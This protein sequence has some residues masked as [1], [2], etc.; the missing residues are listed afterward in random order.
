[1][2]GWCRA[3]P[4]GKL[5]RKGRS[6]RKGMAT[7]S[8][9]IAESITVNSESMENSRK[10]ISTP[11]N[12]P[13]MGALKVAEMPPAA[14]QATRIRSLFSGIRIH[15]P[16]PGSQRGPDLHDRAFASHR[17]PGADGD[18]RGDRFD[19]ADLG[20]DPAAVLGDGQH[21]LG[22][23]VAAGL[24]GVTVDQGTVDDAADDRD[25]HEEAQAQPGQVAAARVAL[26]AELDM[27]GG[28]PGEEVDQV[29]ERHRAQPGPGAHDQSN[30]EQARAGTPQP[31]R[32]PRGPR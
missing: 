30:A 14:P 25:D 31:A 2:R 22:N 18:G 13:V 1:M 11:K 3:I 16:R 4:A 5:D 27:A 17:P 7:A 26:L 29:P 19:R 15:W 6:P 20:P 24:A 8:A 28:Q 10:M 9:I 21:H 12:T 23:A 32:H